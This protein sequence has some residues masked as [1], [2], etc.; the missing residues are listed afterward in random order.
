MKEKKKKG[1]KASVLVVAVGI[2]VGKD[3]SWFP[4]DVVRKQV[5]LSSATGDG[6]KKLP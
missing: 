2:R 3:M 5:H 6:Q 4:D 1:D